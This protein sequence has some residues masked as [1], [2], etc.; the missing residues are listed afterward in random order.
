MKTTTKNK[1]DH[2]LVLTVSISGDELIK[3]IDQAKARLSKE[4]SVD[5]F[6]KGKAPDKLVS[7]KIPESTLKEEALQ[8]S[9]EQ[10]FSETVNEH[11]SDGPYDS[12][13]DGGCSG[14]A[15]ASG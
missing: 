11:E 14:A 12:V 6:R 4:I 7:D 3:Y 13:F 1:D 8:A 5:G 10:S 9:I 2:V 15:I